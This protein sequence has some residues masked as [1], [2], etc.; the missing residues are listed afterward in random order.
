[1]G[2][3]VESCRLGC[4]TRQL[5]IQQPSCSAASTQPNETVM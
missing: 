2:V 3:G 5:I 4:R 1:L